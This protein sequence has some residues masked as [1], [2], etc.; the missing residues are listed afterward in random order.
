MFGRSPS[1]GPGIDG[2]HHGV[3]VVDV[4]QSERVSEFVQQQRS[5]AQGPE[6]GAAGSKPVRHDVD[7][8]E[9]VF[10]IDPGG[11]AAADGCV[12]GGEELSAGKPSECDSLITVFALRDELERTRAETDNAVRSALTTAQGEIAQLR[13]TVGGLRE[14]LEL[15]Q[16]DRTNAINRERT[17][18]ADESAQL[19]NTVQALRDQIEVLRCSQESR[20]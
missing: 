4:P 3:R 16:I 14:S 5:Y 6:V 10:S 19:Q 18:F 8:T 11:A 12:I 7:V 9:H 13:H 20:S 1:G 17:L 2:E 15:A